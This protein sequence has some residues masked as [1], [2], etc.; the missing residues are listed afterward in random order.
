MQQEKQVSEPHNPTQIIFLPSVSLFFLDIESKQS[1]T[2]H[3]WI[4]QHLQQIPQNIYNSV[5]ELY[6]VVLTRIGDYKCSR[7][8]NYLYH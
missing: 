3:Q 7:K 2:K 6:I 4:T 1:I 5:Y 8:D